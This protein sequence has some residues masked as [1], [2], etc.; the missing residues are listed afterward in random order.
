MPPNA[1]PPTCSTRGPPESSIPAFVTKAE[2]AS[3]V[4]GPPWSETCAR[5]RKLRSP[6][7]MH[8]AAPKLSVPAHRPPGG[9]LK[10]E[11]RKKFFTPPAEESRTPLPHNKKADAK[12]ADLAGPGI[13]N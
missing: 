3:P 12:Q 1:W 4:S 7:R 11:N 9:I 5:A 2:P 13:G 10:K 8:L 6:S